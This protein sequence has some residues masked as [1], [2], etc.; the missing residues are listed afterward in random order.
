MHFEI[1]STPQICSFAIFLPF[2]RKNA[3]FS[4]A[5]GDALLNLLS[6]RRQDRT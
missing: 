1:S 4:V 2:L 3:F 6:G 5:T